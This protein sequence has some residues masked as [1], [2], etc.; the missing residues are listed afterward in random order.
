MIRQQE[1]SVYVKIQ[2][3]HPATVAPVAPPYARI[4]W[5]QKS[6]VYAK[7]PHAA[8]TLWG[9]GGGIAVLLEDFSF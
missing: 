2:K 3:C 7:T 8:P 5:R 1:S 4:G 9:G 6:S